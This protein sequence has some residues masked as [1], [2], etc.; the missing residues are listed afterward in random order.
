MLKSLTTTDVRETI[1]GDVAP[2]HYRRQL[3]STSVN[4]YSHGAVYFAV[5]LLFG[6]QEGLK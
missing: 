3:E 6:D 1:L 4:V 2:F 5:A